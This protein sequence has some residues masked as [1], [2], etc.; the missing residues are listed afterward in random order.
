[1]EMGASQLALRMVGSIGRINQQNLRTGRLTD[2]EWSRLSEP[3]KSCVWRTCSST[4]PRPVSQRTAC[5]CAPPGGA[6]WRHLGL[7]IIDY[8]QLMSGSGATRKPRH[9][10]W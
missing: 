10:D 4:K 8:L 5:P 9:R 2:D 1:M 6:S 3:L 7:I